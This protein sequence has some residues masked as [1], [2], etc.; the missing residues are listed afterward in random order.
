MEQLFVMLREY[1]EL[2]NPTLIKYVLAMR[3]YREITV[4]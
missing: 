3:D 2:I 4:E 1:T